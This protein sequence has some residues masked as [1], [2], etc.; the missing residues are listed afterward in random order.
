MKR[1][2]FLRLMVNLGI[3]IIGLTSFLGPLPAAA[4]EEVLSSI[5]R[6][7]DREVM[8]QANET[9]ERKPIAHLPFIEGQFIR[10]P[11]VNL[12]PTSEKVRIRTRL[13]D[14]H[15]GLQYYQRRTCADCH[16]EQAKSMHEVRE[17]I[18][19]RQCHGPDPIGG[20]LY[21]YSPMNPRHRYAYVCSKC[22]EGAS[23]SFATYFVHAPSPIKP[24]T[25]AALPALF[26][27]FW[28]MVALALG[29]F[30][31]FLPHTVAWGLR[32]FWPKKGQRAH[33][34]RGGDED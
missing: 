24:G 5:I 28:L 21:Y 10:N 18:T 25:F 2:H 33:G 13:A 11:L 9:Y 3:L 8:N 14:A 12:A 29:T 16:P 20:I 1:I 23:P 15:M 34:H 6:F 26:I 27:V 19:C 32:E 30:A 7:R 31:L 4:Q 17:G 22:H